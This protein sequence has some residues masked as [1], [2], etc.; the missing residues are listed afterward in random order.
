MREKKD[1]R[2]EREEAYRGNG[3]RVKHNTHTPSPPIPPSLS[4]PS[5]LFDYFNRTAVCR[6][7]GRTQGP[8]I[9][10]EPSLPNPPCTAC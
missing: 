9:Q 8:H 2:K 7:S 10:E 3:S 5:S 1:V 4:L 6:S